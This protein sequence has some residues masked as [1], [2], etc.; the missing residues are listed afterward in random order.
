MNFYASKVKNSFKVAKKEIT[1]LNALFKKE[2]ENAPSTNNDMLLLP[3][4]TMNLLQGIGKTLHCKG[5]N[6][7]QSKGYQIVS[8]RDAGHGEASATNVKRTRICRICHGVGY[9][10]RNCEKSPPSRRQHLRPSSSTIS[11]D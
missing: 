6:N 9:D 3:T 8:S 1:R 10:A 5:S 11:S 7:C 4:M 2:Y